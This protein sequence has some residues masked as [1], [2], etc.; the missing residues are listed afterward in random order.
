[1]VGIH[2][3]VD[4]VRRQ[5]Q[6]FTIEVMHKMKLLQEVEWNRVDYGALKDKRRLAEIGVWFIVGFCCGICG[7]ELML[8]KLAGIQNSLE[9][10]ADSHGYFKVVLSGRTKGDQVSGSKFSFLCVNITTDTGSNPLTWI[11][12]LVQIWSKETD[13][14]ERLLYRGVT[15]TK[16]NYY[17]TDFLM[18]CTRCK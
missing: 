17:E 10:M 3:L 1:M 16:I 11:R 14:S 8:I 18:C 2:K 4:E 12:R 5:D 13:K 7:E 15:P 9:N 6:A